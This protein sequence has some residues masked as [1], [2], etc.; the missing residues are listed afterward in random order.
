MT[1]TRLVADIDGLVSFAQTLGSG[2]SETELEEL[3]LLL[4][5][6]Q[7]RVPPG[8]QVQLPPAVTGRTAIGMRARTGRIVVNVEKT[9]FAALIIALDIAKTKGAAAVAATWLGI[10][11][12][13]IAALSR[14]NGELCLF[15]TLEQ[16]GR[17]EFPVASISL[18][19]ELKHNRCRQTELPCNFRLDGHCQLMVD[20]IAEALTS[21]GQKG[22][23]TLGDDGAVVSI[24]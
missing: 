23:V 20:R 5:A 15:I 17:S 1:S 14:E 13:G 2:P 9:L 7:R 21:M 18:E 22:A 10:D 6:L 12:K 4:L 3:K 11:L 19:A 16:L 8:D 24:R